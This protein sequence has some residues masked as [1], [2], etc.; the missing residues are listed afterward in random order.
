MENVVRKDTRGV[1]EIINAKYELLPRGMYTN[2]GRAAG[3]VGIRVD[4]KNPLELYEA[5]NAV[6]LARVAGG[7]PI[8]GG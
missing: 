5:E 8:C 6:M 4:K 7:S 2:E 3:F 1:I